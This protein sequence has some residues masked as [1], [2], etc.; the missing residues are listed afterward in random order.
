MTGG[1]GQWSHGWTNLAAK[2]SGE[3]QRGWGM[4]WTA[5]EDSSRTNAEA[6]GVAYCRTAE[7]RRERK[8]L[9][10]PGLGHLYLELRLVRGQ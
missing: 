10:S 5:T 3:V 9:A 8:E 6:N 7:N 1:P 4:R 2:T